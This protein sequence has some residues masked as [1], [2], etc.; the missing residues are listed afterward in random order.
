MAS[1]GPRRFLRGARRAPANR[2]A[3]FGAH[4][5][6]RVEARGTKGGYEAREEPNGNPHARGRQRVVPIDSMNAAFEIARCG[7]PA[8]D[9]GDR[10]R[11]SIQKAEEREIRGDSEPEGEARRSEE[12]RAA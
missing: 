7:E 12:P 2:I 10:A 9:A 11:E 8:E 4:R 6:R 5:D 3:S 1:S